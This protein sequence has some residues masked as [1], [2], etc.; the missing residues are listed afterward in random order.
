MSGKTEKAKSAALSGTSQT[1]VDSI[2][3]AEDSIVSRTILDKSAGTIT[4]FA[5]DT[6]QRLSEHTAPYDA[7]IQVLDGKSQITIGGKR[8]EV[9]TG[10]IIIMPANVPH[11]VAA[12]EKFKMMLIMI[13]ALSH[14]HGIN[15]QD[16][17]MIQCPGQDQRFWKPSDISEVACPGCGKPVE[18]FKDEPKLRCSGCG[19]MI[20]NP[21]IDTGCTSWC[22]KAVKCIQ[23]L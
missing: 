21:N 19:Q 8:N 14:K 12:K 17:K 9:S 11:S 3:Y 20:N 10:R 15:N 13:R 16:R 22:Q 5:F 2:E 23:T 7:V 18:F 6:G 1:L 4:L